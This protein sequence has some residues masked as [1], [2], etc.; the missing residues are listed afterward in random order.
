MFGRKKKEK[1]NKSDKKVD[2]ALNEAL[3]ENKV[4]ESVKE[5]IKEEK[6]KEKEAKPKKFQ[7][8]LGALAKII[9]GVILVVLGIVFIFAPSGNDTDGNVIYFREKVSIL[10]FGAIF[11]VYGVT[12]LIYLIK[13]DIKTK[14]KYLLLI[15]VVID[16]VVGI[17]LFIGGANFSSSDNN[18]ASFM[19]KNF[20]YFLGLVFYLRGL[21][22]LISCIFLQHLTHAKEFIINIVLFTFGA[23]AFSVKEFDVKALSWIL[24][25]L[26]FICGAYTLCDGSY[27][28][29]KNKKHEDSKKNKKKEKSKD[30]V[31]EE[32]DTKEEKVIIQDKDE[33]NDSKYAN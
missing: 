11:I 7:S 30:K 26:A 23:V 5:D 25:A 1:K 2:E 33:Q 4:K 27:Y 19:I 15:E 17:M 10:I 6:N 20:K 18:F 31:K 12:R 13:A 9:A 29:I 8:S 32:R 3:D 14:V 24:V 28:Y 22:Y 21:L 16:V